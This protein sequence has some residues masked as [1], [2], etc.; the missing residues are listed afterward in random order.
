MVAGY[1]SLTWYISVSSGKDEWDRAGETLPWGQVRPKGSTLSNY[2][3]HL[4][5][6]YSGTFKPFHGMDKSI[7]LHNRVKRLK[8]LSVLKLQENRNDYSL[9][10]KHALSVTYK[11]NFLY[12]WY[13]NSK[14]NSEYNIKILFKDIQC[15]ASN[16]KQ[17]PLKFSFSHQSQMPRGDLTKIICTLFQCKQNNPRGTQWKALKLNN[18]KQDSCISFV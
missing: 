13:H 11:E 16:A 2:I 8:A 4:Q 17:T 3:K 10:A 15:N 1:P 9:W 7:H 6:I 5:C 12:C 14:L 18:S